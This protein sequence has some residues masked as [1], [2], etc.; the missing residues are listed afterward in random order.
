MDD[1]NFQLIMLYAH[2]YLSE[3]AHKASSQEIHH[4]SLYKF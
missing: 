3:H 1:V 4:S 2:W